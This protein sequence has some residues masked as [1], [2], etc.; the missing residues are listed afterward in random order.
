MATYVGTCYIRI[1][2]FRTLHVYP[3][4]LFHLGVSVH[5]DVIYGIDYMYNDVFVIHNFNSRC[6]YNVYGMNIRI[7]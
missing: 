7:Y 3:Q 1:Y 2:M 6:T 4:N 5:I